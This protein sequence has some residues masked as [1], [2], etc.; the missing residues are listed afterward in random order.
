MEA[1]EFLLQNGADPNTKDSKGFTLL[2]FCAKNGKFSLLKKVLHYG[3]NINDKDLKG[4]TALDYSID[5]NDIEAVKY[6]VTNGANISDNS[7]MLALKHNF[8]KIVYYFDSLDPNK[9]VF[10]KERFI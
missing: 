8:K 4:Y 5:R 7:Y 9:Q 1:V 3:A 2:M 6:L 10:L